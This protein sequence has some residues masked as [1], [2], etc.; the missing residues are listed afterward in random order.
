MI[1]LAIF[2]FSW[3]F[4]II[5]ADIYTEHHIHGRYAKFYLLDILIVLIIGMPITVWGILTEE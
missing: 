5:L 4:G 3:N 1:Y 2:Y